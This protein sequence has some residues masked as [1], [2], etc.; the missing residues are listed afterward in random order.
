MPRKTQVEM[1]IN[2]L[3][4]M[5]AALRVRRVWPEPQ[6]QRFKADAE[7][8]KLA[9]QSAD[10]SDAHRQRPGPQRNS[11]ARDAFGQGRPD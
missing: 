8:F 7:R 3:A 1:F 10:A 9:Y 11:S 2:T 6:R 5:L 4:D